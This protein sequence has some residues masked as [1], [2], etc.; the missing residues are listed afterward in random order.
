VS[1]AVS[2]AEFFRIARQ[3]AVGL[4]LEIDYEHEQMA[5]LGRALS[6]TERFLDI[7]ANQGL[8][9]RVANQ[10]LRN[11]TIALV[12]ANP[13]LAEMLRRDV[14]TWPD[15]G[16]R[17]E[18][19]AVAAG[20]VA[21]KLPFF[22]HGSDALGTLVHKGPDATLYAEVACEPLD[23][24]FAPQARTLIKI[25]VEGF[26]YRVVLGA[27]R[28]LSSGAR[29]FL[30]LHGWGDAERRKYPFHVISLMYRRGFAVSRVGNSYTYDFVRAGFPKR[31]AAFLRWGPV[32]AAKYLIRRL[33]LRPLVYRLLW[34][35][36]AARAGQ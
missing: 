5:H 18:V 11:G 36:L 12:E 21:T 23:K 19:F 26:E 2:E 30:E 20:D 24:L 27:R 4:G 6:G 29:V 15:N 8:Y 31:T 16:N 22:M 35:D 3:T 14:A 13:D 25:D 9:A 10:V 7:G 28:L 33:G 32:F 17:I 34:P 1:N